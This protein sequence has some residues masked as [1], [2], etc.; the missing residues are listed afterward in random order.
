MHGASV[1]HWYI[2]YSGR[3]SCT[4]AWCCIGDALVHGTDV[5]VELHCCMVLVVHGATLV[6]HG[7]TLV[8]HGAMLVLQ[9]FIVLQWCMILQWCMVL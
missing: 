7:A 6:V 2:C 4:A 8:V 3:W 1:V 5:A 9:W